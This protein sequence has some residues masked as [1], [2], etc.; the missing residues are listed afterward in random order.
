MANSTWLDNCGHTGNTEL[1]GNDY[2]GGDDDLENMYEYTVTSA[3]AAAG[4]IYFSC[5]YVRDF[6]HRSPLS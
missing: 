6:R 4:S 3:D 5:S 1:A 2:G